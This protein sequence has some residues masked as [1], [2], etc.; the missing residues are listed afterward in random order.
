MVYFFTESPSGI[1][2]DNCQTSKWFI[3][4]TSIGSFLVLVISL[5]PCQTFGYETRHATT[6]I[7]QSGVIIAQITYSTFATV[8]SAMPVELNSTCSERCLH[9]P[10]FFIVTTNTDID[11]DILGI[12][13]EINAPCNL[14]QSPQ[15][16]KIQTAA[17]A[18]AIALSLFL[19]IYSAF[20]SSMITAKQ[21][22][23]EDDLPLFCC[24]LNFKLDLPD[25]E[26]LGSSFY[27]I[28]TLRFFTE[29]LFR[30]QRPRCVN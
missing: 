25:K 5:F 14:G 13:D 23:P 27:S 24:C 15:L 3:I 20:N 10:D 16:T 1:T 4:S 2:G 21:R 17:N 29:G 26:Q 22:K 30:Y 18:F 19:T 28:L 11:G 9:V 12:I 6:G 7:L 8:N